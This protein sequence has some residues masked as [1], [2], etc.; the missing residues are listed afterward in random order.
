MKCLQVSPL[1]T[2]SRTLTDILGGWK[3]DS[4]AGFA[5][6]NLFLFTLG[7]SWIW[8]FTGSDMQKKLSR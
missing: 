5:V 2:V 1:H 7:L 4:V 3:Y 6:W 8:A